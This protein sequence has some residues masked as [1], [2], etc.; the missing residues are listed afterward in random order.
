MK[1]VRAPRV[2][3]WAAAAQDARYIAER[4]GLAGIAQRAARVGAR[5]LGGDRYEFAL[6]PGDA[7]SSD[8]LPDL[9]QGMPPAG[10]PLRIGWI[11]V[12][13]APG[14][15]GHTTAFRLVEALERAG[16][17]CVLYLYD[18]YGGRTAGREAVIRSYWPGVRAEVRDIHDGVGGADALVA[19]SWQTAHLAA[20]LQGSVHRCFYLVQDFEPYFYP[21]GSEYALAEDTYRFGFVGLT[22]G[23]W[24]STLL[25]TS[26][27]MECTPLDFGV[28]REIYRYDPTTPRDGVVFYAK[29]TVARRGY[30]LGMEALAEFARRH[31]V[32][33]IHLF[34]ESASRQ[35]FSFIDHGSVRPA[36]LAELYNTCRVG[37]SLSFT[38]ISLIPW[39]L[40]GCGVVPVINDAEHNRVVLNNERVRWAAPTIG[41]LADAMSSAYEAYSPS[42]GRSCASSVTQAR[43][44]VSQARAVDVIER[45]LRMTAASRRP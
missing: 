36:Q 40:L 43:W 31:P 12:P 26:Y 10:R 27:G 25:T 30:A 24:L 42:V 37:L 17:T 6:L 32:A 41:G 22:I 18:R 39:E 35:R 3:R 28:D 5:R 8:A 2:Q 21:H 38:N 14:S 23:D 15:G 45:Q 19:T 44:Q 34:G 1:Q 9:R 7:I 16:H 11:M 4:E 33:G 13:P 29:P 20:R